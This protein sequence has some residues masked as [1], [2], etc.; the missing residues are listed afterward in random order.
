[1]NDKPTNSSLL[2][3][4]TK[5]ALIAIAAQ[6]SL[7]T[8]LVAAANE[9]PL[10]NN[11]LPLPDISAVQ[12]EKQ[13]RAVKTPRQASSNITSTP[14]ATAVAMRFFGKKNESAPVA[15][16][17]DTQPAVEATSDSSV[18]RPRITTETANTSTE[19][20]ITS[21]S[22]LETNDSWLEDNKQSTKPSATVTAAPA[23]NLPAIRDTLIR[24]TIQATTVTTPPALSAEAAPATAAAVTKEAVKTESMATESTTAADPTKPLEATLTSNNASEPAQ[25][26]QAE[27]NVAILP[28]P[29]APPIVN[30]AIA[31]RAQIFIDN[32]EIVEQESNMQYEEMAL[33]DET[34]S[35]VK[36]G[37]RFPI[38]I[39]SE[40]TSRT[41]KTG[42]PVHGRLKYDLKIGDRL[43][44]TKG[45]V[46]RGHLNYSL[47]ARTPMASMLSTTRFY[48]NS[49]CLGI[50]FDEII[51]HKGEHIPLVAEPARSALYVK[52]KGEG[53]VLGINHKG[54]ITGPWSQ[55]LQYKAVRVGM[56]FAMAPLGAM[57]FGAM[58][59]ALGV[60]GAANPSFA[61]MRP[62]GLN[63]RH[64]RL[65]GFA[66]GFLSGV[67]GSFLIEDTTVKGQEAVVKPGD[68]FLAELRQEFTGE[69]GT[70]AEMLGGAD[71]KVQGEI[72]GQKGAKKQKSKKAK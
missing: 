53:R 23:T 55:Q 8:S 38:V 28:T 72:V 48:R 39:T 49:G 61:F 70:E 68:E 65:K 54:Q 71:V 4:A 45:C 24:P 43:I 41:S 36:A 7:G 1:M 17:S 52:N 20:G 62:V 34:K 3:Q 13:I 44:A 47:K 31:G 6:L 27:N 14:G 5:G 22:T 9:Q 69:P 58:P 59:V 10:L 26:I 56:N 67:P 21:T 25:P 51:S 64:R 46:V 15:K 66:W 18:L 32:D 40:I 11:T 42:D 63:V 16:D 33:D 2:N 35:K 57:T 30:A 19:A 37:A 50:T 60:L 29:P 12:L